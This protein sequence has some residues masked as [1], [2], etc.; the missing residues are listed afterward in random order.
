MVIWGE[1]GRVGATGRCGLSAMEESLLELRAGRSLGGEPRQS[2]VLS[3][4]PLSLWN[5]ACGKFPSVGRNA[6]LD[7]EHKGMGGSCHA[8]PGCSCHCVG[9]GYP[10][11]DVPVGRDL[12]RL[13]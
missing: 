11:P 5:A 10:Q 2:T 8:G 13:S 7:V 3:A 9:Y 1:S 12:E 6:R 4:G